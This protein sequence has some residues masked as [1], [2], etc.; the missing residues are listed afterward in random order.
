QDDFASVPCHCGYRRGN[1]RRRVQDF[2]GCCG[3]LPL[4]PCLAV[5][6]RLLAIE[7]IELYGSGCR[8]ISTH[9]TRCNSLGFR[10]SATLI[11][12]NNRRP[13]ASYFYF[14]YTHS[15]LVGGTL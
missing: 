6:P 5:H 10:N 12:R 11:L 15:P 3:L 8:I 1:G 13:G 7:R 2:Q 4:L 9:Y 14:K